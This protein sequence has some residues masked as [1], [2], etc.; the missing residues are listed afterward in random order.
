MAPEPPHANSSSSS[1]TSTSPGSSQSRPPPDPLQSTIKVA[2]AIMNAPTSNGQIVATILSAYDLPDGEVPTSVTMSY[3][4]ETKSGICVS[5]EVNTG[6]PAA[7]HRDHANSFKFGSAAGSA[8]NAAANSASGN[9]SNNKPNQLILSAP[10]PTLFEST[11]VFKLNYADTSKNLVSKCKVQ[12]NLRVNELQWLILNLDPE[13]PSSSTENISNQN[14]RVYT[15]SASRISCYSKNSNSASTST[16]SLDNQPP[17]L[18]LKINL[19]GPHRPEIA[20]LINLGN[21]WF[22]VVDVVTDTVVGTATHMVGGSAGGNNGLDLAKW[23]D[24]PVVKLL[25]VP[26]VPLA[27]VAVVCAPIVV[28]VLIV[29]IP[30]L[31]PLLLLL[32]SITLTIGTLSSALYFSTRQ[33]RTKLH[34]L[35]EPMYLTFLTTHSGQRIIYD[36]GPRPSPQSL[37]KAVLPTGMI[38]KLVT[39]LL[40]DFI[41]SASYLIP[42]L[43]E[44]FDLTWAPTSMILVG[45]LYDDIMPNLKYVALM[46]ELLPL[47][48]WIPSAMLGWV[49]EFGPGILEEWRGRVQGMKTAGRREKEALVHMMR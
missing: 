1:T 27:T 17:T 18:R 10:L 48:D 16:A 14:E 37:A 25:L 43:G 44:A 28:G 34:H 19:L 20:A 23:K 42:L 35:L 6:P 24:L 12:T 21:A 2:K 47:T 40:I 32:L 4:A 30:F 46:E 33:G 11:I 41:G 36:V 7:K 22:G 38:G 13:F 31:L 26:T 3:F 39:S 5:N 15:S 45:A 9:E 8:K 49:R 29:G